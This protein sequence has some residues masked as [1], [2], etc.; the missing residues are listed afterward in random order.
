MNTIQRG[1]DI[2]TQRRLRMIEN[3]SDKFACEFSDGERITQEQTI[4][5]ILSDSSVIIT[6][7]LE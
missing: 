4:G 3:T 6:V 5:F 2:Q 1:S 7:H